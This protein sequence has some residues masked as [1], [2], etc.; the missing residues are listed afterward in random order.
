MEA[1]KLYEWYWM[2]C[3][4]SEH[5]FVLD[6]LRVICAAT[7]QGVKMFLNGIPMQIADASTLQ[8]EINHFCVHGRQCALV[9]SQAE[10]P[11]REPKC[12]GNE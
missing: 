9:L 3:G 7:K 12:I 10:R 8:N 6:F 4:R 5:R 11:N 2:R 1:A